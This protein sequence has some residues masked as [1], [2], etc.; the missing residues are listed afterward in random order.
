MNKKKIGEIMK[1]LALL[2]IFLFIGCIGTSLNEINE[3]PDKYVGKSVLIKGEVKNPIKIGK[4]SGFTL[5]DGNDS[6]KISSEE[7]PKEGKTV[8]I[9]GTVM[10][11]SL[12]GYYVLV[13]EIN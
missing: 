1:Y 12:F 9:K 2:S 6:I 5:V 3:D 8:S 13:E 4:L 10:K 7:I 11:D